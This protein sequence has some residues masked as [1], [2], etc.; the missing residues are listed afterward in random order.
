MH[1]TLNLFK[2]YYLILYFYFISFF[3]FEQQTERKSSIS[4]WA[5]LTLY[6]AVLQKATQTVILSLGD[7]LLL[8][9]M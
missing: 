6:W 9:F 4:Y 1:K 3:F 8:Q 2:N 7:K 5:D